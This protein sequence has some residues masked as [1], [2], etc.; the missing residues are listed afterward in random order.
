MSS[1]E[2]INQHYVPK[3]YLER[4]KAPIDAKNSRIWVYNKLDKRKFAATDLNSVSQINRFYRVG[5]DDVVHAMVQYKYEKFLHLPHVQVLL[6]GLEGVMHVNDYITAKHPEHEKLKFIPTNFLENRYGEIESKLGATLKE[7]TCDKEL[8]EETLRS[9]PEA[10]RSDLI[11][12]F[13]TQYFRTSSARK[14]TVHQV[15]NMFLERNGVK[16][17]L[18]PAQVENVVKCIL[19][20]DS[21]LLVD[22]MIS[23]KIS[24]HI[25]LNT[26]D[27][28]FLTSSSP[29]IG[30]NPDEKLD[31]FSGFMPLTPKLSMVIRRSEGSLPQILVRESNLDIVIKGNSLIYKKSDGDIYCTSKR[32]RD[33]LAGV[34]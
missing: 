16:T 25:N 27:V 13:C 31:N 8:L 6:S 3:F 21:L 23:S 29:A 4:W 11:A 28:D 17:K 30:Y 22:R 10:F 20:I 7:I 1:K 32:Q 2:V 12:L 5:M 14:V 9:K 26:T 34:V 18:A 19:F 33:F 24:V 15:R